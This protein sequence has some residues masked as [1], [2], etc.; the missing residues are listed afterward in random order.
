MKCEGFNCE[1]IVIFGLLSIDTVYDRVTGQ[2]FF[3][4]FLRYRY[5][6]LPSINEL[7][8]RLRVSLLLSFAKMLGLS[9][10]VPAVFFFYH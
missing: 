10:S 9:F 4:L 6:T 7:V 5:R 2:L 1:L 3:A 8:H